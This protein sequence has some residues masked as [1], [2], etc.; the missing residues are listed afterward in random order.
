VIDLELV[1]G[2]VMG[3]IAGGSIVRAFFPRIEHH[4]EPHYVDRIVYKPASAR[5]PK[6][7]RVLVPEDDGHEHVYSVRT[8][9]VEG[10]RCTYCTHV[11]MDNNDS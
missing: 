4:D 5:P 3:A 7:P 8:D 2:A 1:Y 6:Q 11:R 9:A 10:Y